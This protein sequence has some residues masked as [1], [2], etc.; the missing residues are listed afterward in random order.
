MKSAYELAMERLDQSAP[1]SKITDEQK[2]EI[3]EIDNRFKAKIAEKKLFIEGL[4]VKAKISGDYQALP[5]LQ[6]QL[7]REVSMFERDCEAAKEAI[8]NADAS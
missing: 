6:A 3:A 5:E 4:I 7:T 8:R 2:S 1:L